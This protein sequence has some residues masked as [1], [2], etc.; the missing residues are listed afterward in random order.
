MDPELE[1]LERQVQAAFR[2]TLPRRGFDA[3]LWSRI[4]PQRRSHWSWLRSF[5]T[6]PHRHPAP[7][8]AGATLAV[9]VIGVGV[10]YA[11]LANRS[12]GASY[13]SGAAPAR[14]QQGGAASSGPSRQSDTA[15]LAQTP[16]E[17]VVPASAVTGL[18][19]DA[20]VYKYQLPDRAAADAF[21]A[22]LGARPRQGASSD[23]TTIGVY[24]GTNFVLSVSRGSPVQE[25]RYQIVIG[26]G[27]EGPG[28]P[29]TIANSY[30]SEHGLQPDWPSNQRV[31]PNG[32]NSYTL[33]Y[34]RLFNVPGGSPAPETDTSG[35]VVGLKVE[36]TNGRVT[37][38]SG[39]LPSSVSS[40]SLHLQR[41]AAAAA[42]RSQLGTQRFVVSRVTLSYLQYTSGLS[43]YYVPAYHLF[44]TNDRGDLVELVVPAVDLQ[45]LR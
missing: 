5:I 11:S 37:V 22:S 13:S 43:G 39:P 34:Y 8:L 19:S 33:L 2:S 28:D 7:A 26:S 44:G 4:V 42:T 41:P 16:Y 23:G 27:W 21:A 12:S 14:P 38:V 1:A 3:E 31:I 40:S 17:I 45:S 6:L 15:Q 35:Q 20:P 36:V 29:T 24:D 25:P 30:L 9:L 10:V 18:P 32:Q